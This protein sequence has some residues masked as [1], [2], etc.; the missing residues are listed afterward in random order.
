M[1]ADVLMAVDVLQDDNF[2]D[3]KKKNA[4]T[5]GLKT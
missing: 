3:I 2:P 5:F 4:V 1:L